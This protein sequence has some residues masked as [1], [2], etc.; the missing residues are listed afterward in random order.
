[1]RIV[2]IGRKFCLVALVLLLVM[3]AGCK[4]GADKNLDL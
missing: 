4:G 3:A 2:F 1:M